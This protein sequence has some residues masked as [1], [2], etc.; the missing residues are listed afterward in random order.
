MIRLEIVGETAMEIIANLQAFSRGVVAD[1]REAKA[2]FVAPLPAAQSDNGH[3][4]DCATHREPAYPNGPCDCTKIEPVK[5]EPKKTRKPKGEAPVEPTPL[6][7]AIDNTIP[8]ADEIRAHVKGLAAGDNAKA[9]LDAVA[10]TL[11]KYLA[12][13]ISALPDDKRAA[14]FA[15]VKAAI[16]EA[17]GG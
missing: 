14:F 5:A 16:T 17:T 11:T 8:T 4:S 6:E 12:K 3:D 10:A 1:M 7:V 2:E 13:N 9:V 15:D